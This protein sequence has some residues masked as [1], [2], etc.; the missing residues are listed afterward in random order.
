MG[1]GKSSVDAGTTARFALVTERLGLCLEAKGEVLP[2]DLERV[3][4]E[5][6]DTA[7]EVFESGSGRSD[8]MTHSFEAL[9]RLIECVRR[10]GRE[11]LRS[12]LLQL[13]P[14][15]F[16]PDS[17]NQQDDV[18]AIVIGIIEAAGIDKDLLTPDLV[19]KLLCD[20]HFRFAVGEEATVESTLARYSNPI[21]FS[22]Y[23]TKHSTRTSYWNFV[24]GTPSIAF[25]ASASDRSFG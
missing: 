9:V 8:L 14:L 23:W 15:S 5:A 12:H 24:A 4:T 11:E 6:V 20:Q 7:V 19:E 16:Q 13:N 21:V 17:D 2:K 10:D 25:L 18:D 1:L 22:N 3:V